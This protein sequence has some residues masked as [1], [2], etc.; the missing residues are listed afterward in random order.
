MVADVV[1][2]EKARHVTTYETTT[3]R[4]CVHVHACASARVCACAHVCVC[5]CVIKEK[6][7]C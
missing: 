2:A 4:T 7:P 1:R 6:A 5:V 3:S